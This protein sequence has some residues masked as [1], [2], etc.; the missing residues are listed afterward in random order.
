MGVA[1]KTCELI[2]LERKNVITTIYKMKFN[3][4]E[5]VDV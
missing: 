3:K 4:N 5:G 2:K 1:K